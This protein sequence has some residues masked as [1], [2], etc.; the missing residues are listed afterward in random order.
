[1]E[2]RLDKAL[3]GEEAMKMVE[4]ALPKGDGFDV[5]YTESFDAI[6]ITLEMTGSRAISVNTVTTAIDLDGAV[7]HEARTLVSALAAA[8]GMRLVHV[9]GAIEDSKKE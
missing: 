1:M 8:V 6:V 5:K 4:A 2:D 7:L 3:K 9:L